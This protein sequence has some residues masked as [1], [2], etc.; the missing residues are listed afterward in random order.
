[1]GN[2]AYCRFQNVLEDLHDCVSHMDDDVSPEESR[3]RRR[4]VNLCREIADDYSLV[5]QDVLKEAQ[6]IILKADKG[7]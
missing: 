5:A 7:E 3:S 2:M 4:L 1:M 6:N